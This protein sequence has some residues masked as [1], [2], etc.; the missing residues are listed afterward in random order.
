MRRLDDFISATSWLL[1]GLSAFS[2]T[3]LFI[4][5]AGGSADA[6]AD[7]ILGSVYG[8]GYLA[9]L[10]FLSPEPGLGGLLYFVFGTFVW[11]LLITIA[12]AALAEWLLQSSN[13][14]LVII[15][16]MATNL[17]IYPMNRAKGTFVYYLPI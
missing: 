11:P 12:I 8:L 5:T 3:A 6:L 13:R 4:L 2:G 1:A 9:L 15:L 16:F 7:L 17:L 10:P 14:K